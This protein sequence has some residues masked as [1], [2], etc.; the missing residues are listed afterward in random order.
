MNP[1]F[2]D[3]EFSDQ[4][5]PNIPRLKDLLARFAEEVEYEISMETTKYN[6][7]NDWP[8]YYQKDYYQEDYYQEDIKCENDP[9]INWRKEGF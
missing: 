7:E 4:D 1:E 2:E 6:I 3:D 5:T 9:K 8:D